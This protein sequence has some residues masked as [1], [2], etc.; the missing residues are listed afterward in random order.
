MARL[1]CMPAEVVPET[2]HDGPLPLSESFVS[3][4][5]DHVLLET[6]KSGETG[7]IVLRLFETS[8]IP[9]S[10]TVHLPFLGTSVQTDIGAYALKTL[11]ITDGEAKEVNLFEE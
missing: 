6:V 2:F 9:T 3:A 5:C 8:G 1:L 10:V 7:G 4:D 11:R